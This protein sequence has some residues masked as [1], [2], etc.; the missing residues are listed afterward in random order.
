MG[1]PRRRIDDYAVA[2]QNVLALA[3]HHVAGQ[4][5][6]LFLQVV[7]AEVAAGILVLGD[8][9]DAAARLDAAN[10][11]R[12]LRHDRQPL[13]VAGGLRPRRCGAGDVAALPGTVLR[14]VEDDQRLAAY[15]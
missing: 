3:D 2:V 6:G 8:H 14:A 4:G 9:R 1:I 15:G 7:N 5:Y 13:P 12:A 11:L 10:I